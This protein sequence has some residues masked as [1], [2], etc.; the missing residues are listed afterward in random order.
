MIARMWVGEV[1]PGDRDA[2]QR[3]VEETGLAG[4]RA[5]PGNRGAKLLARDLDDRCEFTCLSFWDSWESIRAFAGPDPEIARYYPDDE[6]F[7]LSFPRTVRHFEVLSE[8]EP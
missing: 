5:T 2:Y 3:Y 1:R 6:R 7:L 8:E 4:Y